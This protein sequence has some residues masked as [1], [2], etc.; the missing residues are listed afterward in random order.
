[1]GNSC[2]K[3]KYQEVYAGDTIK[4]AIAMVIIDCGMPL[5]NIYIEPNGSYLVE[6]WEG[7]AETS[8]LIKMN[9][10]LRNV[11]RKWDTDINID[12]STDLDDFYY[13][14]NWEIIG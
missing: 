14:Y 1:M 10:E 5:F 7:T 2:I 9:C 8:K 12:F 6:V 11:E 13:N 3:E 4:S